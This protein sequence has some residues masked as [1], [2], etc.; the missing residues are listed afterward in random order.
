MEKKDFIAKGF[1]WCKKESACAERVHNIYV[2][3][4]YIYVLF[5][6]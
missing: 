5:I 2:T 1:V 3:R 4:A 6:L